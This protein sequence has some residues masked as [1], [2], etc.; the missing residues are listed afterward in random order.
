MKLA[1]NS[2]HVAYLPLSAK[3]ALLAKKTRGPDIFCLAQCQ[4]QAEKGGGVAN[5]SSESDASDTR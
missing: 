1:S 5:P 4:T 2:K 3:W